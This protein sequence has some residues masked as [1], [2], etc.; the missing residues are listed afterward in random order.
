MLLTGFPS[1]TY[2]PITKNPFHANFKVDSNSL[3]VNYIL[4]D[5]ARSKIES[6]IDDDLK[7]EPISLEKGKRK[8]YFLSI[9]IY[10][11]TSPILNTLNTVTRCEINTY[12]KRKSDGTK[13]TIILD[14]TS[15][16][17]SMDPVN[18]FKKRSTSM[19]YI[20]NNNHIDIASISEKFQLLGY[21][22]V[23]YTHLRAH[24]T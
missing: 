24:E 15:N 6:Y 11:V 12:V 4:N 1:L 22:A 21:I 2:N 13:G 7:L 14:Y 9:N 10:N 18:I 16:S 8:N 5:D 23:S 20:K 19:H 3:Y 17:L